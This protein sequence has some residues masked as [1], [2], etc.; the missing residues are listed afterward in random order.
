MEPVVRRLLA[1]ASRDPALRAFAVNQALSI[2]Y[3][4]DDLALEFHMTFDS[5]DVGGEIG[6]PQSPADLRLI[7]T[8]GMMDGVLTGQV[9]AM[10]AALTGKLAFAGDARRAMALQ[11][12]QPDLN[13]LYC[14][15][16][17]QVTRRTD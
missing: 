9:N 2:H 3:V 5:G 6:P 13:R 16:R 15:A 10:R 12:I 1:I 17:N 8:A 7:A 11:G 14:Q 4:L